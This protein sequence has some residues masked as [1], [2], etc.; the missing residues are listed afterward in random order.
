MTAKLSLLIGNTDGI[1]LALTRRLLQQ[2]HRVVGVSRRASELEHARYRHV[3]CDV[4]SDAYARTL[5]E[6]LA[7]EGTFGLCV[8]CAGV[9]QLLD[10]DH[11]DGEPLV[12][13][14]NLLGLVE[15]TSVLLPAMRSVGAGHFVGLSSIGDQAISAEAPSYAASK[16]GFSAYLAGLTLALSGS[17]VAITNVRFGFVDTKMAKSPVRPFMIS[18]ERAVD[19]LMRGLESRPARL[20]YPWR[21]AL[22]VSLLRWV[23]LVRLA[24]R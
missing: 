17:G 19:V 3:V 7:S 1:G 11:L 16:A 10:L 2:G 8:Y 14:T 24:F 9:G 13:R 20:T 18:V 4:G 12:F 15:T 21:T 6:L 22:L 5:R 23:A